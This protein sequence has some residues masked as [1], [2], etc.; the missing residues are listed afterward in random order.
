MV[1]IKFFKS[2]SDYFKA[3][4]KLF[5]IISLL[6][7][8]Y[9]LILMKSIERTGDHS[10]ITQSLAIIIGY[11]GAYFFT[12]MDYQVVA[13]RW[14]IVASICIV[15]ILYT[16]LFEKSVKGANGIDARAWI[17][18]PGGITFQ[19][20]ELA[21]VGFMI[22]FA[23]HLAY[24]DENFL[25]DD[26]KHVMFLGLHA[27]V[28]IVLTHLQSDDGAGVIFF[29]MF[30][31]MAFAAGIQMRYFVAILLGV[32]ILAPIAWFYVLKDYQ[33]MRLLIQF[34][35]ESDPWGSGFQQIQGRISIASGKIFGRG[36]FKGPRV[37]RGNVVPVQESDYIFSVAGEELGFIGCVLIILLIAALLFRTVSIAN[38]SCD[39]L[40]RYMCFGFFGMIF[41]QTV[42]NLGMCLCILPVA[43]VTLP[44]FSAGGSSAACLYFALGLVQ[45]VYMRKDDKDLVTLNSK[46]I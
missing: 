28:P 16:V 30:L 39:N 13:K 3:T 44:F 12:R 11:A 8:C 22:T 43:G 26:F 9:C 27:L 42:L 34:D 20:S 45:N 5:W 37:G 4:D 15:L 18:L 35:L 14:Y 2:V 29:F 17:H 25:K 6:I 23:R 21:K 24:L 33:K 40:G 36:L 1:D 46:M 31:T 38:R 41:S 7:S 19:P 10:I 32:I